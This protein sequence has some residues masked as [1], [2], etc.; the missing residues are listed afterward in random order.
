MTMKSKLVVAAALTLC[1][2]SE[3]PARTDTAAAEQQLQQQEERLRE[4]YKERDAAA[5][6]SIYADD[7]ALARP[8]ENLARGRE[9]IDEATGALASDPNLT[10]AFS[11]NR[12]QVA[13]SGDLAYTRGRYMMT[14]TNPATR[15]PQETSGHYLTVWQ[16]RPDGGWKAV[17]HFLTAGEA[18]GPA[19]RAGTIL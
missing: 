14:S 18:T 16:K 1:A 13:D 11:A 3:Q 6:A 4:A 17:E 9:S 19:E 7:A 10:I 5:I 2:C 8:G 15:A 12:M